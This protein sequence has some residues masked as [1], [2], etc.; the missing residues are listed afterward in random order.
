MLIIKYMSILLI[1]LTSSFIGFLYSKRYSERV[2][3]LK[4][5]KNALKMFESKIKFTYEPIPEVFFEISKEIKPN[6]GKIFT[7]ASE[8]M[9]S[10]IASTAWKKSVEE[11]KIYNNFSKEDID[12]IKNLSKLLGSTDLEGQVNSIK[13]TSNFL[14]KQIEEAEIEKNKNIKLYK[15]LGTGIGLTISIILI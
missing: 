12:I 1:F 14:D 13:L 4:E 11:E 10:E 5:M 6:I 3:D 2:K 8:Y 9:N 7:K 15:T